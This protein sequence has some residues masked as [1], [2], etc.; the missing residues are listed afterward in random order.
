MMKAI[1]F[2]LDGVIVSTDHYHYRA[3]K[4]IADREGV[5]FDENRNVLLRGVSREKSLEILL[6]LAPRPYLA[7]EKAKLAEEKN[8]I[9]RR[10]LQELTP[11]DILPGVLKW[12][13]HAKEK[14]LRTAIGSSSKNTDFILERI[15]LSETF[16]TVV[17]GAD[18]TRSKPAPD[19]FLLAAERLGVEPGDCWVVEDAPAGIEAAKSAGMKTIGVGEYVKDVAPDRWSLTLGEAEL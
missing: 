15:G 19:I 9:Y 2:D 17:T 1:I 13:E 3:W 8:G 16:D 11:D 7:E 4:D 12:I 14:G 5:P 6:E 10:L 18:V